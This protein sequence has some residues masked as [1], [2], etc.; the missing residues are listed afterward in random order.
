MKLK[1][2]LEAIIVR[3]LYGQEQYR[4]PTVR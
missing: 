4:R 1:F 3:Q 2:E